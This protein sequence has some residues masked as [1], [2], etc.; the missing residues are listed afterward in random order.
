MAGQ[1][2]RQQK[3]LSVNSNLEMGHVRDNVAT[4]RYL[5]KPCCIGP[6]LGGIVYCSSESMLWKYIY[7]FDINVVKHAEGGELLEIHN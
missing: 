2:L 6:T 5:P 1:F 7:W 4:H 3:N